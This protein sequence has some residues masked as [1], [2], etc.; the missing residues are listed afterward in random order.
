MGTREDVLLE[1]EEFV[2]EKDKDFVTSFISSNCSFLEGSTVFPSTWLNE[3]DLELVIEEFFVGSPVVSWAGYTFQFSDLC[4]SEA[5][6][7][8]FCKEGE[9]DKNLFIIGEKDIPVLNE[10]VKKESWINK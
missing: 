2:G 6:S 10:I 4:F 5:N 9:G 1:V 7:L 8:V 3:E